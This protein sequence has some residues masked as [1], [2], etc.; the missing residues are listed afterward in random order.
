MRLCIRVLM[1]AL[2]I[3]PVAC[4]R[5]IPSEAD[6][7]AMANKMDEGL[8]DAYNKR[9]LDGFLKNYLQTPDLVIVDQGRIL[10]G[11]VAWRQEIMNQFKAIGAKKLTFDLLEKHNLAKGDHVYGFGT[12]QVLTI[13]EDGSPQLFKGIYTSI[14][15]WRNGK[16]VTVMETYTRVP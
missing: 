4:S 7:V 10:R 6:L 8:A 14:K 2:I 12:F 5:Q 13:A 11:F 16:L 9:D 15:A 3:L 1:L